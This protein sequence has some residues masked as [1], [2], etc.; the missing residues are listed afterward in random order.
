VGI[1]NVLLT[2]HQSI[3]VYETNVMYFSFNLFG[4]KGL[5]VFRALAVARLQFHCN[6]ATANRH[7]SHA[8]YQKSLVKRLLRMSKKCSKH[9]E[10]LASQ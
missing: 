5:Y 1:L 6:C 7:Y 9:G 10:A 2:V 8:M 3:S 4:V